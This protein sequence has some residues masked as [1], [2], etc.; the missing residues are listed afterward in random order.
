MEK[1]HHYHYKR[2]DQFLEKDFDPKEVGNQLDEIMSDL[3]SYTGKDDSY[4]QLL[5]ERHHI[6]RELRDI[7]WSLKKSNDGNS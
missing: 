1:P 7:F 2:L 5:P 4:C 3:V 6:L